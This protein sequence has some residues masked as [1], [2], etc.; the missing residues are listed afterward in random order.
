[1]SERWVLNAS[2]IIVLARVG[3]EHLFEALA[4]QVVV[5]QAVVEDIEAGPV[6]DPARRAIAK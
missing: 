5:P 6:G 4:V 3:H 1:M 2:P